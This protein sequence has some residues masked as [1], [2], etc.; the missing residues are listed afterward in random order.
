MSATSTKA[1]RIAF[2]LRRH[3]SDGG[4][5]IK[6]RGQRPP[7]I[8]GVSDTAAPLRPGKLPNPILGRFLAEL[9]PADKSLLIAPGVGEDVAAVPMAGEDVLVLKSDPVTLAT[10]SIGQYAITVNVN[11]VVTAGAM[12][13]W[14]LTSLLFPPGS[15]AEEVLAVMRD[16]SELSRRNGLILCGGH[17]EITDAVTRPVV[18]AQVA[19]TVSRERVIDKRKMRP[20]NRILLT[21]RIAIEGTCIIAREFSGRLQELGMT[22]EEVDRCRAL[23]AD[24][25]ISIR[26]EAEI[27]AASGKVTA[28]HDITEGG[29]ATALEELGFAGGHRLRVYPQHIPVLSETVRVCRLLEIHPLGLIGSGSL[30]ICCEQEASDLLVRSLRDAGIEAACIGEVLDE[31]MGIEALGDGSSALPWPRFEVDEITRLFTQA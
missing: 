28:M 26:K 31:G 16:L 11:D 2:A 12:P 18:V 23:L 4:K 29:L 7:V 21:K 6:Q 10:D 1:E 13:R 17:T 25:G 5:M 8:P 30:L 15:S 27:A 24:P 22:E 19:G 20:G 3:R 14:V 9:G